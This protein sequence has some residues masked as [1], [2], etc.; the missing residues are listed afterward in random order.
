[1]SRWYVIRT[2]SRAEYLAANELENE[3]FRVF[4]PRVRSPHPRGGHDDIPLFPGYLFLNIDPDLDAWP[5]FRQFPRVLGWVRFG[6]ETP[7]LPF[8]VIEELRQR[9]AEIDGDG[10]LWRRYEPGEKVLVA[11][12]SI[13]SNAEVVEGSKSPEGRVKV[14]MEFMGRIVPALVPWSDLRPMSDAA[15]APQRPL[16]RTRGKRRWLREFNPEPAAVT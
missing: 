11:V 6:G 8:N 12:G 14:I 7:W 15:S 4:F 10:G 13:E 1:M 9:L 2:E 3:G 16:R 5:T